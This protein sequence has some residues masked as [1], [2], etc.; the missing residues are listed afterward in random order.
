MNG[1]MVSLGLHAYASRTLAKLPEVTVLLRRARAVVPEAFYAAIDNMLAGEWGNRRQ[2]IATALTIDD[3][4]E[5]LAPDAEQLFRG[6][7]ASNAKAALRS[8]C[9]IIPLTSPERITV[10]TDIA[11]A[12]RRLQELITRADANTPAHHPLLR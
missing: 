12:A 5:A 3:T 1:T 2:A 7:C 10:A 11:E 8:L 4:T 6:H 9:T